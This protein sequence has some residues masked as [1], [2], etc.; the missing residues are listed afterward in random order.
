MPFD[1]TREF[2][3]ALRTRQ[4]QMGRSIA[5]AASVASAH[6]VTTIRNRIP[7]GATDTRGMASAF[8]G[9]AAT[10]V[11]KSL[12]RAGPVARQGHQYR[13]RVGVEPHP[14]YPTIPLVH[15]FG[16]VIRARRKKYLV[17]RIGE[18]WVKVRSVFIRPK[19][20]FG[21]GWDAMAAGVPAIVERIVRRAVT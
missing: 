13:A 1:N 6:A 21:S 4:E 14:V 18:K 8:P 17:F 16:R 15:E 3:Q 7:P 10:G 19:R 5:I 9:Y 11:L 2:R 12:V 20:Y